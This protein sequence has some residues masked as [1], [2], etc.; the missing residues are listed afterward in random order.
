MKKDKFNKFVEKLYQKIFKKYEM[1]DS[2]CISLI[3]CLLV[4]SI[5]FLF[6][7]YFGNKFLIRMTVLLFFSLMSLMLLLNRIFYQKK[8]H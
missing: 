5:N 2:I 1:F 7:K 4:E 6:E 8:C 3:L